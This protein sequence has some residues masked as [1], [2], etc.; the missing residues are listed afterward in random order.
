MF[1]RIKIYFKYKKWFN[2]YSLLLNIAKKFDRNLDKKEIKKDCFKLV[3]YFFF[4]KSYITLRTI[5]IISKKGF[6]FD[7]AIL[8]R[9]LLENLVN[10]LYIIKKPKNNSE[11]FLKYEAIEKY[12]LM[13]TIKQNPSWFKIKDIKK[14]ILDNEQRIIKDYKNFRPLFLKESYWSGKPIT[15]MINEV[16]FSLRPVYMELSYLT[17]PSVSTLR[18]YLEKGETS[19]LKE[20]FPNFCPTERYLF[21]ILPTSCNMFLQVLEKFEKIFK[22]NQKEKLKSVKDKYENI[23]NEYKNM[24]K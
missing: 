18:D 20:V 6:G 23:W 10:L 16:E 11:L 15:E 12:K 17:H 1:K 2:L 21:E 4:V 13:E 14:G 24:L 3:V 9:T 7:A 19:F 22:L 8:S 5:K